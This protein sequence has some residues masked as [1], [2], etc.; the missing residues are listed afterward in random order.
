MAQMKEHIEQTRRALRK[1]ELKSILNQYDSELLGLSQDNQKK[2]YRKML[3]SPFQLFRGSAFLFYFDLMRMPLSYHTPDDKPT[4]LQGDLHFENFSAFQ[5]E[6]GQMVF[7]T[8]DFDEGFPGSYLADVLR[9][10][11]SIALYAEEL[12]YD[13]ESQK[14]YIQD[15][16][17]AYYGQ[18]KA[19]ADGDEDP[20]EF[21]F[22]QHNTEGPVLNAIKAVE[23]QQADD[24]LN[25]FT[26]VEDGQRRFVRSGK[27]ESLTKEE[28]MAL[29]EAWPE[30]IKSIDEENQQ[31][32]GFFQIKDVV[33]VKG[34]GT[35]SIGLQRFNI[36]IEGDKNGEHRDDIVLEAKEAGTPAPAHFFT[37]EALFDGEE[38][39]HGRRVIK[40]QKA[41]HHLEDPFLGYFKIGDHHFYVRE[42]SPFGEGVNNEE[43]QDP[44][45]MSK[46][47]EIMGKVTAKVHARADADADEIKLSHE[48]EKEILHAIGDHLKGFVSEITSWSMYYKN[49]VHEDY[50]LFCEWCKEEF[51]LDTEVEQV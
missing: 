48:T 17:N 26:T 1:N 13:E 20:D 40:S 3:T 15:Y 6:N 37:H 25:H 41:M 32:N 22:T 10:A 5:N 51:E 9:M 18:M 34:A 44:K 27:L 16:A 45:N 12:G 28:R 42:K 29:E 50:E 19:F 2:K 8:D 4:W 49:Q 43:L 35:G 36:L 33:K 7:D 14:Q 11:A 31:H 21:V 38:P 39:H 46:T 23:K 47:V 30:Y 24:V